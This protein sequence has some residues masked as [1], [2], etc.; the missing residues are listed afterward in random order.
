MVRMTDGTMVLIVIGILAFMNRNSTPS[1][2]S[3]SGGNG[4][5]RGRENF[6]DGNNINKLGGY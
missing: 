2:P 1:N 4:S 3:N 6:A 5:P